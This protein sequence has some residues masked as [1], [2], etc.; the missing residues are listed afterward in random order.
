MRNIKTAEAQAREAKTKKIIVGIVLI[1]LMV[2]STAGYSLM[3]GDDSDDNSKVEENG[4]VFYKQNGVWMTSI[5][6][7]TFGFQYLPSEI[8]NIPIKGH[9]DLSSYSDQLLYYTSPSEGVIE[10]LNNIGRYTLRY[11]GACLNESICEDDLP[12]KDCWSNIIITEV[13]NETRVY[14]NQSCIYLV[15]DSVKAADAFLYKVLKIN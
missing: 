9:Y 5:N 6:G 8:A 2:V 11:Q 13:G 1:S 3:Q 10:I 4:F 15:G 14:N 12:T 7:E